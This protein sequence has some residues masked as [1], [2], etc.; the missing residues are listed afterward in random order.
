MIYQ[1][2]L[3]AAPVDLK[4]KEDLLCTV[5]LRL[6]APNTHQTNTMF[7]SSKPQDRL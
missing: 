2:A 5:A 6:Q 3:F 7:T 4:K 1:R